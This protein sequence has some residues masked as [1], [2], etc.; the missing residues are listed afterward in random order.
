MTR[1]TIVLSSALL[2]GCDAAVTLLVDP[3]RQV[4]RVAGH[5]GVPLELQ[6][7]VVGLEIPLDRRFG[8]AI[9][10]G[11]PLLVNDFSHH[12]VLGG[13]AAQVPIG[14]L[15]AVTMRVRGAYFGRLCAAR[16]P[17]R[18]P[19][20][21]GD[22]ALLGGIG[23]QLAIGLETS[24]LYEAQRAE[25]TVAGALARLGHELI[26]NLNTPYL[27]D[28]LCELTAELLR[29]EVSWTFFRDAERREWKGAATFGKHPRVL[30]IA[31][32]G[33]D[34]RGRLCR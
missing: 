17:G 19:F 34:R 25:A 5:H 11:E 27:L 8:E 26:A 9:A 18:P 4:L 12:A 24:R 1:L 33:A 6:A 29:C 16:A 10:S 13:L 31:T 21:D 28:R 15:V 2:L 7:A 14:A 32:R 3:A 20:T 22:V 23:Q 30:G